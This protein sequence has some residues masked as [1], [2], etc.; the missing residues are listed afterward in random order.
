[1]K[2]GVDEETAAKIVLAIIAG[3]VPNVTLTF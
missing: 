1:M 3:E 2:H